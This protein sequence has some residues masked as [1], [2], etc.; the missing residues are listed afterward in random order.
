MPRLR[1]EERV[2]I[3]VLA[4]K[5]Q[6]NRE[7]ARTLGVTEGAVRYRLRRREAGA[8]DGRASAQQRKA[9]AWSGVIAA[10]W[11]A[12]SGG[13]RPPNARELHELLVAEH[14]YA[15]GYQSVRRW[16]RAKYPAPRIRTY[17]RVETPPGA[18][19]Q[20]DWGEF[21]RVDVGEGPE[22]L[23]AFVMTLSHSRKTAV[24]W[25]RKEDELHWLSCHNAAFRRLDGVAAVNRIDNVKT[26]VAVG[27]GAWGVNR[28]S[29]TRGTRSS[30]IVF[31]GLQDVR[32]PTADHR[33]TG[34]NRSSTLPG[35]TSIARTPRSP[36]SDPG[37]QASQ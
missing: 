19:S 29:I 4:D 28:G 34:T 24:V 31:L 23:H 11:D 36:R 15:G 35:A 25:S 1:E 6:S 3:E 30:L 10:W 20:T 33:R 21:P 2:T 8:A 32:Q 17:R 26:A 18:Q 16:L 27:A 7:I 14:G 13:A 12:K 5:G 22:P 37:T 9:D